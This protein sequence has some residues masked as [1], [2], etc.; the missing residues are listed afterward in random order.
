MRSGLSVRTTGNP[1]TSLC[2]SAFEPYWVNMLGVLP[3]HSFS[4]KSIE[5]LGIDDDDSDDSGG[6]YFS[7][8]GGV[9]LSIYHN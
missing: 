1:I 9:S 8:G 3:K 5:I 4:Q 2:T 7:N 6:I